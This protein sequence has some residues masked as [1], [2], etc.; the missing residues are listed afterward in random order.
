MNARQH[1]VSQPDL[2]GRGRE[3]WG[4]DWAGLT[5]YTATAPKTAPATA[6]PFSGSSME[7]IIEWWLFCVES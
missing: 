5:P 1:I 2:V 6:G 3:D 7:P 4:K